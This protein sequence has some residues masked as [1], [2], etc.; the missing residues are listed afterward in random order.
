[1]RQAG[2]MNQDREQAQAKWRDLVAEQERSGQSVAA[3][4]RDR[5][6]AQTQLTY[7][8]RRV[9]EAG[10]VPFVEVQLRPPGA[11]PRVQ[12]RASGSTTIEVL[13][14]NGR[15]LMVAAGFDGRHLRALLAVVE[16]C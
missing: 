16:S 12:A 2:R 15:S 5:E 8:K 3:F 9:R 10:R 11:E 14:K 1:M 7:W 13:L 4:C 6:L